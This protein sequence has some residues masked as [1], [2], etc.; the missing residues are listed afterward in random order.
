MTKTRPRY[1]TGKHHPGRDWGQLRMVGAIRLERR[2][3]SLRCTRAASSESALGYVPLSRTGAELLFE[4]LSQRHERGAHHRHLQL[5]RSE[6]WTGIFAS[7]RLTGALLDRLTHHVH[8]LE[9]NGDSY[10][11]K[12]SKSRRRRTPQP[13]EEAF[14]A[15]TGEIT[16]P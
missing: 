13:T 12:Q 4:T 2:A 9:M 15:E 10:R 3:A 7:E 8:I 1:E 11:L 14:D 6:E 5:C 16:V